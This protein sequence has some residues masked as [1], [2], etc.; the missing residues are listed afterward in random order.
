[1]SS[2]I[3][4]RVFLFLTSVGR[5]GGKIRETHTGNA[6]VGSATLGGSR[7]APGHALAPVVLEPE[8]FLHLLPRHL[9]LHLSHP[10]AWP[11][12]DGPQWRG[13]RLPPICPSL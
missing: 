8:E 2:G 7:R 3:P 5:W 6:D 12:E 10:Q 4:W 13:K 11:G 9:D 1:M